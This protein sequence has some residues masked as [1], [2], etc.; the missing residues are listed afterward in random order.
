MCPVVA[1]GHGPHR[2][3]LDRTLRVLLIALNLI[4]AITAIV[5]GIWVIPTLPQEWLAGTPFSSFLIPAVALTVIVGGGALTSAIGL[6][7]GRWW[8]PLVSVGTG[9]AIAVFE[10]VETATMSLHFWLHTVG[11]EWDPSPPPCRSTSAP[12]SRSQCCSSPS[13]SCT[14]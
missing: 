1:S 2:E 14:A 10:I 7:L 8:A 6:V 5:G 12:G 3:S 13:S 9:A 4:L 11:L